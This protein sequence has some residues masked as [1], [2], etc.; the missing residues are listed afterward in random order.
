MECLAVFLVLVILIG[1]TMTF[2]SQAHASAERWS[3]AFLTLARKHSGWYT[4][5]GWFGRPHCRFRYGATMVLVD[6]AASGRPKRRY[7]QVHLNFPDKAFR[8]EA[9]PRR[10]HSRIPL[11]GLEDAL[12]GSPE[13]DAEYITRCESPTE[14]RRFFSA[15]VQLQ[16]NRMRY[17]LGNDDVYVSVQQGQMLVKKDF[18]RHGGIEQIE[19]LVQMALDL[20][21][22]AMLTRTA[23]IQFLEHQTLQAIDQC[24][25]MVCGEELADDVV[26]C[27]RCKTPHHRDCWAYYGSCSTY[28]C[29]E[30][31]FVVPRLA[32]PLPGPQ[33]SEK[34]ASRESSRG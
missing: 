13:F 33:P 15:G 34:P 23:G 4:S 21:D 31:E 20:F 12:T 8:C 25:C 7:L 11:R 22:Q 30:A 5:G 14:A 29:K 27:R 32:S 2:A 19:D 9:F 28:G 1:V 24:I 17:L 18:P 26:L 10:L 6:S 3:R 16:M